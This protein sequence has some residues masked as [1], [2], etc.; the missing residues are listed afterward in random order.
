[1]ARRTDDAAGRLIAGELERPRRRAGGADRR[2]ASARA[3][4]SRSS[5]PTARARSRATAARPASSGPDDVDEAMLAGADVLH[6]AGYT[7]LRAPGAE[8][9]L[10]LA[11]T[12]PGA[13]VL[14]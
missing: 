13:T 1:M 8:A 10:R 12:P 4:W 6:V 2:A 11:A 7:L 14:A 9:A 5:R 3:P